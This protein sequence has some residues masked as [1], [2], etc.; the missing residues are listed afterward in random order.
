MSNIYRDVLAKHGIDI[1][2]TLLGT[3]NSKDMEA[4]MLLSPVQS[5][6]K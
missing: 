1:P 2:N 6:K 5:N 3:M 4:I